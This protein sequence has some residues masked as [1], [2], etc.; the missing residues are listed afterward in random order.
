MSCLQMGQP[1]LVF[2][3]HCFVCDTT[4][5]ILWQLGRRQLVSL[6]WLSFLA[7]WGLLEGTASTPPPSRSKPSFS[8][9]WRWQSC[10]RCPLPPITR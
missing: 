6:H 4:L 9:L 3:L 8:I 5:F 10:P 1:P 7:S 2:L